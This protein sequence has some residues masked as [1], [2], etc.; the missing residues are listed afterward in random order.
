MANINFSGLWRVNL[1]EYTD[2]ISNIIDE[3][4]FEFRGEALLFMKIYNEPIPKFGNYT[5][6]TGPYKVP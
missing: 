4:Y 1:V 2:Q 6:Y 3:V 5:V